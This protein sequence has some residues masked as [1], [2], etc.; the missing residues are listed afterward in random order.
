MG[1][2]GESTVRDKKILNSGCIAGGECGLP[3]PGERVYAPIITWKMCNV[4]DWLHGW[5]ESF[6]E[7]CPDL[8]S[9]TSNLVNVYGVK[10]AG[11]GF[12]F[13]PPD[14]SSLR[15]GCIG[16]PAIGRDKVVDNKSKDNPN[17][18]H[19]RR[20]YTIWERVREGRHRCKKMSK[21]KEL[22]GCITIAA[23]KKFFKELLKIQKDSGVELVGEDD[24]S[25]IK[26]CWSKRIY[27]KGWGP[28]HE[29]ESNP[30]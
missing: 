1:G 30:V 27:P 12:G 13:V 20:I 24:I 28:E 29:H 5:T 11:K 6:A 26:E 9:I 18:R 17:Y 8:A 2:G 21:G 15:F 10:I 23:R 19:L 22:V 7:V 25:F 4:I 14:Y 16:C 3:S